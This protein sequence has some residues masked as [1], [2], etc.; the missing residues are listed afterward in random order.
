MPV[1]RDISRRRPRQPLE[2]GRGA[3]FVTQKLMRDGRVWEYRSTG[4]SRAFAGVF[5]YL[6]YAALAGVPLQ[7][8]HGFL[9][10]ALAFLCAGG[11][12]VG[13]GR[14]LRQLF[15]A[16]ARFDPL[17]RRIEIPARPA[18]LPWL[19]SGRQATMLKFDE[20]AEIE[21]LEKDIWAGDSRSIVNVELNLVLNDGGRINLVSHTDATAILSEANLLAGL[22]GIPV[23]DG[24]RS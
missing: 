9:P 20:V 14:H 11:L 24:R 13:I 4:I 6:G 19:G 16:G 12:F 18:L 15:S 23:F 7:L 3:S 22:L 10:G 5:L 1:D 17:N 21:M 8:G 2:S